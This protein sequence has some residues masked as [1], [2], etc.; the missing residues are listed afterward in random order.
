MP[1]SAVE[2]AQ[3]GHARAHRD[4]TLTQYTHPG[5]QDWPTVR[6]YLVSRSQHS[7]PSLDPDLTAYTPGETLGLLAHPTI[8][9]WHRRMRSWTVPPGVET[10]VF[11]PCAKTKPWTEDAV[12]ASR[13]YTAYNQLQREHP[14]VLF[15]TVSEPLGVVPSPL[16]DQFPQYDNPGLFHDDAQRS[17]MTTAQ[18]LASPFGQKYL[19]PFD[20]AAYQTGIERLADVIGGFLRQN[21][22][23]RFVAFTDG[24]DHILTTHSDMLHRAAERSGVAVEMHP[25][26]AGAHQSPYQLIGGYLDA[27]PQRTP[28]RPAKGPALA[29]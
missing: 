22:A 17:G 18:W 26:R 24:G 1:L 16:W 8:A 13:L 19:I 2:R 9:S 6:K 11:V 21:R 5:G 12:H 28:V 27:L 29:V 15:V 23:L 3:L 14:E 20:E 10:V 25:K 4:G 7:N